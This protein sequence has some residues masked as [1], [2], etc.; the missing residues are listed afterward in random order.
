MSRT[1]TY[2]SIEI[3]ANL[4][5][6]VL[7]DEDEIDNEFHLVRAAVDAGYFTP[8]SFPGGKTVTKI[9]IMYVVPLCLSTQTYS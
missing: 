9:K 4:N 1:E 2:N 7:R 6:A 3:L 8:S 5:T